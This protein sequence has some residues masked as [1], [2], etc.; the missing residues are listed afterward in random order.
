MYYMLYF[1]IRKAEIDK[2]EA[3]F[4]KLQIGKMPQVVLAHGTTK[5]LHPT[6]SIS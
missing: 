4:D 1:R 5:Y 2:K 6:R 3:E